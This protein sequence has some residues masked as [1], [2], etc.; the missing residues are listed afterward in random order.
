M[1]E[2]F[3][4]SADGISLNITATGGLIDGLSIE[5]D[6]R[7][8]SPLHRAPW[9]DHPEEVPTE[10]APHL[11]LLSGDFFCAPFG[12]SPAG[13][14]VPSHGWPANGTW[15][16]R[17]RHEEGGRLEAVFDLAEQ[18]HGAR[19]E[20]RITLR[21]GHPVVYQVHTL[22]GG[23]GCIPIAHHAMIHV[24]GGAALSFSPKDFGRTPAHDLGSPGDG[25][26]AV[27]VYPQQF[28]SLAAVRLRSGETIDATH[29]PFARGHEDFLSLFDPPSAAIGW[30]AAVAV[31]DG[32]VFFALKDAS[33]LCQTSLWM[34]NGGRPF[35]PWNGR[36]TNVLGIE[37]SCTHFGDGI[38]VAAG[39]NDLTRQG[40]RT[41]VDLTA[42]VT[43]RYALGAVPV[44]AGFTRVADIVRTPQGIELVD[45][46]GARH[47]V[48]FDTAF[49][50]QW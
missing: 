12:G 35:S 46:G 33:V 37:E 15:A 34:S 19:V 9:V 49:F 7:R 30:S 6:G 45:A 29:Y 48:P 2:L 47:A 44:P 17:Q 27:F 5:R 11:G 23:S 32:F 1:T 39:E 38:A 8:I 36:H 41:S 40:Y 14:G 25:T 13:S 24:P 26:E 20:K 10:E 42:G 3:F 18:V 28:E 22:S 50:G 31:N 4:L 21:D 16:E 43:V